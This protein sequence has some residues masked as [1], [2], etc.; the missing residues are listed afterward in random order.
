MRNPSQRNLLHNNL[1]N[2]QLH[3]VST[4]TLKTKESGI[5][6]DCEEDFEVPQNG[7]DE[8]FEEFKDMDPQAFGEEEEFKQQ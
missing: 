1:S 7:N 4:S 3:V 5:F 2:N 8:Y 6:F